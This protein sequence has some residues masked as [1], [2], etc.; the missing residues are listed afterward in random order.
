MGVLSLKK[1]VFIISI[2]FLIVLAS[3]CINTGNNNQTGQNTTNNLT[4]KNS[5][6]KH[7]EDSEM[8]FD[9]PE[10]WNLN[11]GN[12]SVSLF[13]GKKQ[14]TIEKTSITA[15]Y[16][17]K[18]VSSKENTVSATVMLPL[19]IVSNKTIKVDG[20]DAQEIIYRSKGD[21]GPSRMEVTINKNGKLFKM[22][23]Y[24]PVSEF[25]SAQADFNVIINSFKIK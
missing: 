25:N 23:L 9:Y 11:P 3:G 19:E 20:V 22:H 14:I 15:A 13:N 5:K 12:Y 16:E 18:T 21:S 24:A 6:M 17:S 2:L 1:H 8:S 7:Y 4:D 10:G